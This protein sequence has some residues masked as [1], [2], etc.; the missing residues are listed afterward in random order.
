M[1]SGPVVIGVNYTRSCLAT[2]AS[3]QHSCIRKQIPRFPQSDRALQSLRTLFPL[4]RPD[5]FQALREEIF[6]FA[7]LIYGKAW[8]TQCDD[9]PASQRIHS[10][11]LVNGGSSSHL[12]FKA[13]ARSLVQCL[14]EP[15]R[16]A[17]RGIAIV[18]E[19]GIFRIQSYDASLVTLWKVLQHAL[20]GSQLCQHLNAPGRRP[21][22]IPLQ[23]LIGNYRCSVA[24]LYQLTFNTVELPGDRQQSNDHRPFLLRFCSFVHTFF[25]SFMYSGHARRVYIVH[26]P[27][28]CVFKTPGSARSFLV[29]HRKAT[30]HPLILL[31]HW[32][33]EPA[34]CRQPVRPDHQ[35]VADPEHRVRGRLKARQFQ[36][37]RIP[38]HEQWSLSAA[39]TSVN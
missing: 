20:R 3:S 24:S 2:S 30:S 39:R 8:S 26:A 18:P 19:T 32:T 38:G 14:T 12:V 1:V 34:T 7:R 17:T 4:F 29:L 36:F 22:E 10:N 13:T 11:S 16:E 9:S 21:W 28:R 37:L 5:T 15:Q 31:L 27:E 33:S 35:S 25:S 23:P 6:L